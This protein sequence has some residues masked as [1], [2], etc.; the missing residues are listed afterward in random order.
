ML[1]FLLGTINDTLYI[2][3]VPLVG[4]I[5]TSLFFSF[6]SITLHFFLNELLA[7]LQ[8]MN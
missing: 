3:F 4:N 8:E 6:E 1:P 7:R 5:Y 2:I